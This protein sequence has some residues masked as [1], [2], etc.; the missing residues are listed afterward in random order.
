VRDLGGSTG[1]HRSN[2][3]STRNV[4][5]FDRRWAGVPLLYQRPVDLVPGRFPFKADEE[6]MKW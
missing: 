5:M 4:R 3:G 2:I 6:V 1:L